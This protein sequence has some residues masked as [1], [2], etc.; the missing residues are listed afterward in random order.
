MKIIITL[1]F[2]PTLTKKINKIL[3]ISQKTTTTVIELDLPKYYKVVK[4][5]ILFVYFELLNNVSIDFIQNES[6]STYG[7]VSKLLALHQH[8]ADNSTIDM[9]SH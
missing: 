3:G 6:R 7:P 9:N 2:L 1:Q 4:T 5:N 8:K